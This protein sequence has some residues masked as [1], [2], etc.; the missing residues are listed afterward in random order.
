MFV[1]SRDGPVAVEAPVGHPTEM[2][3]KLAGFTELVATAISNTQARE[4]LNYLAGEQASLRRVATLVATQSAGDDLFS[5]VADEVR[6]LLDVPFVATIRYD[7]AMAVVLGLAGDNPRISIG[8]RWTLDGPSVLATVLQTG[9]PARMDEFEGLGG[10]LAALAQEAGFRTVVAAPII[11]DNLVWGAIFAVSTSEPL[12]ERSEIRVGEYTEL[13][14]TAISN[15]AARA[16]L[17]ASRARIVAASDE[18]RRRLERDLHDGIQQRLIAL[19]LDV[20][21]LRAALH[22]RRKQMRAWSNLNERSSRFSVSYE[23]SPAAFILRSCHW[24]AFASR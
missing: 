14:A 22:E 21:R 24:A 18:G 23:S 16:E 11:V 3:Q 20:E 7:G 2:E 15:A 1:A 13:V 17:V 10:G 19:N 12:P 6:G 4:D 5:A 8:D 9:K